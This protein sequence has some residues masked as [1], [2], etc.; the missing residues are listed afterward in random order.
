MGYSCTQDADHTLGVI[1]KLFATDGNPNYLTI[2]GRRYFF[3][4][5]RENADGAITGKLMQLL[6]ND[7]LCQEAGS[8]KIHA[9]G[10]LG[11]FPRLNSTDKGNVARTVKAA[12]YEELRAWAMGRI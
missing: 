10:R 12:S 3:E 9:D 2:H 7:T 4:R 1:G 8:V 5:G 6:E 11:L